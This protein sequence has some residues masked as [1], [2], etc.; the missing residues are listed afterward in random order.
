MVRHALECWKCCLG[1]ST[2]WVLQLYWRNK[3]FLLS[4]ASIFQ[5]P[6]SWKS[7]PIKVL[8]FIQHMIR[9]MSHS[10]EP[11]TLTA[12]SW[13]EPWS[14][15][16]QKVVVVGKESWK[17]YNPTR[18]FCGL[19]STSE[20]D[21]IRSCVATIVTASSGCQQDQPLA[22]WTM[23][24]PYTLFLV[25]VKATARSWERKVLF[26]IFFLR[27]YVTPHR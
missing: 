20:E 4:A 12:S 7:I 9:G 3:L 25:H 17:A 24:S 14:E 16:F 21:Q 23:Q 2:V 8:D 18:I 22:H 26:G 10:V 5:I 19:C 6:I 27:L 15:K 13:L 11:T 1:P